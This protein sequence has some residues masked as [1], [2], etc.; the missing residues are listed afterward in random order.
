[1]FFFFYLSNPSNKILPQVVQKVYRLNRNNNLGK[2]LSSDVCKAVLEHMCC[3]GTNIF[4]E[5]RICKLN[6]TRFNR[7]VWTLA[8]KKAQKKKSKRRKILSSIFFFDFLKLKFLWSFL[9]RLLSLLITQPFFIVI[10]AYNL[11]DFYSNLH[12]RQAAGP[13]KRK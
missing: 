5:K 1:M 2:K 9:A 6:F 7:V 11:I 12:V 8:I 10:F 4:T 3:T 13:N